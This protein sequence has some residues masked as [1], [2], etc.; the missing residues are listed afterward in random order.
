MLG[1]GSAQ[2]FLA[3]LPSLLINYA[4]IRPELVGDVLRLVGATKPDAASGLAAEIEAYL[5]KPWAQK[6]LGVERWK[7]VRAEIEK[8]KES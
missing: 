8:V 5:E 3:Y 7:V 2:A 4:Q 1:A 6:Q